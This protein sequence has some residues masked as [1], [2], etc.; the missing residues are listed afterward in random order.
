MSDQPSPL[1]PAA[2]Q[3]LSLTTS[4]RLDTA[5]GQGW[6]A[7]DAAARVAG[8]DRL[9]A[10]LAHRLG[11]PE[12]KEDFL[13]P[14]ALLIESDDPDEI[15]LTRA[16]LAEAFEGEDDLVAD[17]LWEGVLAHARAVDDPDLMSEAIARLAGIAESHG[18]PLAAA[19]Y[20]LEFLNW[21]RQTGHA[22]DP[23]AVLDAFD[24]VIRLAREDGDPKAAAI[25][26]Y[27]QAGFSRL[28]EA[29]DERATEG[30]WERDPKPYESWA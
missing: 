27:R 14:A 3:P 17:T 26:E 19:E 21:R 11:Q 5:I 6:E 29:E 30:D 2:G 20:F 9:A 4:P 24:E 25:F 12:L 22:S 16:E 23:D 13:E 15:A 1:R 7:F 10:W 18:D 28:A 8:T